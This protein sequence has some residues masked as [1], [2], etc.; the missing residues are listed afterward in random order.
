MNEQSRIEHLFKHDDGSMV[1]VDEYSVRGAKSLIIATSYTEERK[2]VDNVSFDTP[3]R[4][5]D[6]ISYQQ[7]F[8]AARAGLEAKM[9]GDESSYNLSVDMANSAMR[10][11]FTKQSRNSIRAAQSLLPSEI[12][13]W[14]RP[15]RKPQSL[16]L[17][18]RRRLPRQR[19][20]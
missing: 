8:V 6:Y 13:K 11:G 7:R 9:D 20:S 14:R 18:K 4:D 15:P 1:I 3:S 10:T 16:R 12:R 2:L 5:L 19:L 17:K